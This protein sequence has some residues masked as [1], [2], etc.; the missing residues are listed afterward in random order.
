MKKGRL[1]AGSIF[2]ALSLVCFAAATLIIFSGLHDV[3]VSGDAAAGLALIA[4]FYLAFI[5]YGGQLISGIIS[6][7]L[8]GGCFRSE[9]KTVKTIAIMP[10]RLKTNSLI[11]RVNKMY[12]P[13]NTNR[14]P[15]NRY[16]LLF[17]LR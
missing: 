10:N 11:F 9:N 3:E 8:T 1:I 4:V 13:K 16:M 12:I 15:M 5:V 2:G 14:K 6:L 17:I 7:I